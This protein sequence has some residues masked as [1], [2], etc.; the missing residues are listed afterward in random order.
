[1]CRMLH[2][3]LRQCDV[4]FPPQFKLT[5]NQAV[6]VA[7]TQVYVLDQQNFNYT[8]ASIDLLVHPVILVLRE[9]S[10]NTRTYQIDRLHQ[11]LHNSGL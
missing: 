2:R 5:I 1:M 11:A 6:A 4:F 9:V 3:S 8:L 7:I 10:Q